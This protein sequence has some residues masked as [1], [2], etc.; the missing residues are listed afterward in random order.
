MFWFS[1]D[2]AVPKQESALAK[3]KERTG[4]VIFPSLSP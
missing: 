2:I 1:F 3:F 4:V